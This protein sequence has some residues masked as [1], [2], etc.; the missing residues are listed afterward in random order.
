MV[1]LL[2]R[3]RDYN[4]LYCVLVISAGDRHNRRGDHTTFHPDSHK[5]AWRVCNWMLKAKMERDKLSV[6]VKSLEHEPKLRKWRHYEDETGG[7]TNS[8]V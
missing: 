7:T 2:N 5:L 1:T 6:D 4:S 3:T 8:H